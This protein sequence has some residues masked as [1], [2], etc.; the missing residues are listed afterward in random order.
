M[1]IH[2]SVEGRSFHR[3]AVAELMSAG[4]PHAID[5]PLMGLVRKQLVRPD[6]P[7]FV[8]EDAFRFAHTLIREV[9]YSGMPKRLRADLHERLAGWLKGR[10][11][12]QDEIVGYHLESAVRHRREI[13][14]EVADELAAEAADRLATA[15]RAALA[16]G[17]SA[18]GA[19]LLERAVWLLGPDDPARPELL[20][21]LC[22][23]LIDAGRL[24]DADKFLSEAIARAVAENDTRLESR[25]LVD[26]QLVR[27]HAGTSG[28]HEQ[29]RPDRGHGARAPRAPRRRPRSMPGVAAAGLDRLDRVPVGEGRRGVAARRG[30]RA[31]RGRGPRGVRDPRLAGVGRG[32][33]ADA[34]RGGDRALLRDPRAGA[35]E[36]GGRRRSRSTRSP[37]CTPC[38]AT[39]TWR[40]G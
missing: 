27:L 38:G 36:P 28:G 23:A 3:A 30:A 26:Q 11:R 22:A 37:C 40:A 21:A 10:E 20:S 17:D 15:A 33:R 2:A 24:A 16:R 14:V 9:A 7:E 18:A 5:A 32:V 19:S 31:A 34:G 6:R 25:A 13:G 8:G 12:V 1:L 29:A 4:D 39:S 35:H